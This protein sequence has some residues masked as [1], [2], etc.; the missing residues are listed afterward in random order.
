M[1]VRLGLELLAVDWLVLCVVSSAPS[2]VASATPNC[3]WAKAWMTRAQPTLDANTHE[4]RESLTLLACR[5]NT[6]IHDSRFYLLA[7]VR[8]VY[9]GPREYFMSILAKVKVRFEWKL[10]VRGKSKLDLPL[11]S[12]QSFQL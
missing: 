11:P 2:E 4:L 8:P 1:C 5:V 10:R 3:H 9:I 12:P 7:P 6:P